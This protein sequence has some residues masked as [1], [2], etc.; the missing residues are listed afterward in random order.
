MEKKQLKK[1]ETEYNSVKSLLTEF[2]EQICQQLEKLIKE[3]NI[4]L[5]FPIQKRV[6]TWDSIQ[7]KFERLSMKVS[8]ILELQD[9]VGL[10]INLLFKKDVEPICKIIKDSFEVVRQYD[11]IDRLKADQFGYSSIHFVIKIPKDWLTVP[12]FKHL[13]NLQAEIQIRTL[14]QH[15]WAEASNFL[16]YKRESSVP[17]NVLRSVYRVSAL[18]ETVD[19]EFDRVL[20]EKNIYR[21]RALDVKKPQKLNVDLIEKILDA[22]LPQD[23]KS[24]YDEYADLLRDLEQFKIETSTE[25]INLISKRLDNA[26]KEDKER[27]KAELKDLK[28]GHPIHPSDEVRIKQGV[29]YTYVGLVRSILEYEYPEDY[30]KYRDKKYKIKFP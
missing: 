3:N 25:L 14:A 30:K 10:R 18:L 21:E 23:N 6:K 12:T 24:D 1:I 8:S 27:V 17:N 4:F 15:I 5:G 13:G 22:Y 26:I 2:S 19:L 11:T 7:E 20:E 29:F 16:Q 28:E 9:L